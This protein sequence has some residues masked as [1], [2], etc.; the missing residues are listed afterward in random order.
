MAI[1]YQF[2]NATG[3]AFTDAQAAWSFDGGK[4]WTSFAEAKTAPARKGGG[5]LYFKLQNDKGNW[6]DFV[7][8]NQGGGMW[9]GNTT[10]VDALV[11]PLTI[12]LFKA[13]GSS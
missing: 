8:Y 12:E 7:E 10:Y 13:D 3:G 4:T 5:R 2:V 9:H 6:Q 1:I 11:I